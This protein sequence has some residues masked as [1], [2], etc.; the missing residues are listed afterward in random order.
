MNRQPHVTGPSLDKANEWRWSIV[1]GNGETIAVSSE[2]YHNYADCVRGKE[3]AREA[4]NLEHAPMG[5][6]FG[7]GVNNRLLPTREG[8][9]SGKL[10]L[11]TLPVNRLIAE[12]LSR[13]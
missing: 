8:P 12:A 1:A 7:L 13:R 4:L 3:I 9:I 6:L 11:G 5:A 2:G 10:G